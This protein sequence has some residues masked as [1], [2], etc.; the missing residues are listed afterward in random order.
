M[1][2][3]VCAVY[4]YIALQT[5][6]SSTIGAILRFICSW[7]G[8]K[9]SSRLWRMLF[10]IGGYRSGICQSI[11]GLLAARSAALILEKGWLPKKPFEAESGEGCAD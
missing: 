3:P 10:K 8:V 2:K 4:D 1:Y 11:S 5:A 9:E 7:N 6:L